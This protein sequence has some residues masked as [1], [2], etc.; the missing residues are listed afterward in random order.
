MRNGSLGAVHGASM[1][2]INSALALS[3]FIYAGTGLPLYLA[4]RMMGA[5]NWANYWSYEACMKSNERIHTGAKAF[6]REHLTA[7]QSSKAYQ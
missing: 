6:L 2:A 7:D 4:S 3:S 1:F 5:D